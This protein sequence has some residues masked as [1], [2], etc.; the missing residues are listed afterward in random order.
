VV[1]AIFVCF[2]ASRRLLCGPLSFNQR[3][4]YYPGAAVGAGRGR[5]QPWGVFLHYV[6]DAQKYYT[7]RLQKGLITGWL[8]QPHP[9]SKL[10]GRDIDLYGFALVAYHWL[11]F[12]ILAAWVLG[13]FVRPI[14]SKKDRSLSRYPA[15]WRSITA[16]RA[17]DTEA[18]IK[19]GVSFILD[20]IRNKAW[21]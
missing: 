6:S 2:S 1:A 19:F 16:K 4:N 21:L 13:Y 12:V 15:V 8:I 10:P 14:C 11:P 3:Q 9:Q 17:V 5:D 18:E 7:L 20:F